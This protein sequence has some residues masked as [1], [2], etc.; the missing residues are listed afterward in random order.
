MRNKVVSRV[1]HSHK[2]VEAQKY[3]FFKNNVVI[4][5][6]AISISFEPQDKI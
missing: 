5:L 2:N 3:L 6:L 1:S 4:L